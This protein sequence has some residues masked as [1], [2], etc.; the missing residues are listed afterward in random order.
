MKHVAT[1]TLFEILAGEKKMEAFR[2]VLVECG[3]V[4]LG[5]SRVPFT[6]DN[7]H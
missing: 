2:D 4:D 7:G 1:Q 3:L 6:Y 5:F